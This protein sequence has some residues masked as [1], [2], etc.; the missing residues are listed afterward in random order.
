VYSASKSS[1][2]RNVFK[3]GSDILQLFDRLRSLPN[4]SLSE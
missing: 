4:F 1:D 2:F 3:G